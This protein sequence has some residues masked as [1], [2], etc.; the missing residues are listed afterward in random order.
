M[1]LDSFPDSGTIWPF[2]VEKYR[3]SADWRQYEYDNDLE[4]VRK[5]Q[6]SID[7]LI[8]ITKFG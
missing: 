7:I 1:L 2:F 4:A 5:I 3:P 6:P 8:D